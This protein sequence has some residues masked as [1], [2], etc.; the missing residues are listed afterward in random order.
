LLGDE[1]LAMLRRILVAL[2][3]L[4]TPLT[5]NPQVF[6]V[7]HLLLQQRVKYEGKSNTQQIEISNICPASLIHL[8]A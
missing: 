8:V 5:I 1:L 3:F 6:G 2:S 4:A 7:A